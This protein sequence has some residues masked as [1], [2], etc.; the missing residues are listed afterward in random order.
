MEAEPGR[1]LAYSRDGGRSLKRPGRDK[2]NTAAVDEPMCVC[3]CWA[4]GE[5][6]HRV[7]DAK[8]RLQQGPARSAPG[9]GA[10]GCVI[11]R[12]MDS[13]TFE[14][15]FPPACTSSH[16]LP[17]LVRASKQHSISAVHST[18]SSIA[19]YRHPPN[20]P[21][22]DALSHAHVGRRMRHSQHPDASR[23]AAPF[24]CATTTHALVGAWCSTRRAGW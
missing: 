15:G 2:C 12:E 23:Q 5:K 22:G 20:S 17:W 16:C 18:L 3:A 24:G 13:P 10:D 21:A 4:A 8:N 11:V 1:V 9:R 6:G 14:H 19:T 7:A